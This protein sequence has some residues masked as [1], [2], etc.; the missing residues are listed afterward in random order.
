[1]SDNLEEIDKKIANINK[2]ITS[3]LN[4]YIDRPEPINLTSDE[5]R[6]YNHKALI[7]Y[8]D[9]NVT[10]EYKLNMLIIQKR[11]LLNPNYKESKCVIL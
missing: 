8:K 6:D 2:Q 11:N 5:L 9:K 10:L 4:Q 3:N 7:E 1:M